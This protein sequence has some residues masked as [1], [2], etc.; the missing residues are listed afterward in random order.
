MDNV[1]RWFLK[2]LGFSPIVLTTP[3]IAS[4]STTTVTTNKVVPDSWK[5]K[6]YFAPHLIGY[7]GYY[8]R[9]VDREIKPGEI[10]L[11]TA[12]SY[13]G[14]DHFDLGVERNK[15]TWRYKGHELVAFETLDGRILISPFYAQIPDYRSEKERLR[16]MKD[17]VTLVNALKEKLG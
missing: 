16:N 11:P 1:R 17:T 10:K 5:F 13:H 2:A 6:E 12:K 7:K 9:E 3:A 4:T 15:E 14:Y 8:Y